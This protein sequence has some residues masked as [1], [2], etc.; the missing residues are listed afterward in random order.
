MTMKKYS[1]K[2][3]TIY[4]TE[5]CNLNCNYCFV[6]KKDKTLKIEDYITTIEKYKD[7]ISN[8]TFFGGEP[9]LYFN[10][11]KQIV[12]Y[13]TNNN[14]NFTYILNTNG[15]LLSDKII[16]FISNNNIL[17]NL[18]LDG[19]EMSN[20]LNRGDHFRDIFNKLIRLKDKNIDFIINYV[21]SPN[22]ISYFYD[23]IS[24]FRNEKI[25]KVCL[26][27]NYDEEW[28]TDQI[29]IFKEQL[30]KTLPIIINEEGLMKIYPIYNKITAILSNK[31][32]NKCNF[33]ND[34]IILSTSGKLYPCIGYY[35]DKNYEINDNIGT[36]S[37]TVNTIKCKNCQYEKLCVNNCMCRM[38]S[39]TMSNNYDINCEF[40][41]IFI[42]FSK[43]VIE[44]MLSK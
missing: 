3:L 38:K 16:E 35:N 8:I 14:Y 28:K 2:C 40:E 32:I 39:I 4:L 27:I 41:K 10:L 42:D 22:N 37:N 17:V 7:E 30:N 43:K 29:K 23:S 36:L 15:L 24:F 18:S 1:N 33:G 5:K 44:N 12:N 34:S 13:N 21:I 19:N 9:L 11:I 26:M 20:N 6:D 25:N 31:K